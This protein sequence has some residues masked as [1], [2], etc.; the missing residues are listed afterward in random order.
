D[1]TGPDNEPVRGRGG[2]H[3]T[4]RPHLLAGPQVP[5]LLL[6]GHGDPGHHRR[7]PSG[8]RPGHPA[9]RPR[10]RPAD[11]QPFLRLCGRLRRAAG[12]SIATGDSRPEEPAP[13][14][15][16]GDPGLG[17]GG[18]W[19]DPR[20]G[21]GGAAALGRHRARVLE[22]RWDVRRQL[23]RGRRQLHGGRR[24]RERL[25]HPVRHRC[26]GR[27]HHDKRL[28]GRDGP[29]PGAL[30]KVLRLY[31]RPGRGRRGGFR[32]GGRG[33]FRGLLAEKGGFDLRPRL[34]RRRGLRRAGARGV[35]LGRCD[36]AGRL[37]GPDRAVVHDAGP[38]RR[39]HAGEPP[40]RR[41]GAGQLPAAPVLRRPGGRYG[42]LDPDR[43][44]PRLFLVPGHPGGHPRPGG[45]R[46]R[47]LEKDRGRDAVRC[48]PGHRGRA[49]HGAR[50]GDLQEVERP[51]D[52]VGAPGDPRLRH[53]QLHRGRDGV[54][55]PLVH[56]V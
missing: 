31:L 14:G 26:S 49:F 37:R 22:A 23:H 54:P 55:D 2:G 32:G 35:D 1:W 8:K 36:G 19:F 29:H 41:G 30:C 48:Q 24:G 52:P 5:L 13:A 6:P 10:R 16:V 53:R 50:I 51:R 4:Y 25:Q 28:D 12:H 45:L 47:A 18:C 11:G 42:P 9:L 27:H 15:Q 43:P 38:P 40:E 20:H 34:P 21:G 39:L 33:V 56:R 7:R 3:R 46:D 17:P 44:G